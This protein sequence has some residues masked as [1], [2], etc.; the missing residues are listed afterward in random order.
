MDRK[1][2]L[3]LCSEASELVADID[4]KLAELQEL[5]ACIDAADRHAAGRSGIKVKAVIA[6]VDPGDMAAVDE[7]EFLFEFSADGD[8]F[9]A[10]AK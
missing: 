9:R 10:L 2:Y 8:K 4:R 1:T 3:G 6:P 5:E 7:P